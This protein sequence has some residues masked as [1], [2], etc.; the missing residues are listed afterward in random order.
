MRRLWEGL[1]AISRRSIKSGNT[2]GR[3]ARRRRKTRRKRF[4]REGRE[5]EGKSEVG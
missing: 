4:L 3:N 5:R 1:G 2:S